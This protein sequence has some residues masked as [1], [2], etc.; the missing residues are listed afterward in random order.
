MSTKDK[1]HVQEGDIKTG[2]WY[3]DGCEM[4]R[5]DP[6]KT[7]TSKIKIN[8]KNQ[9]TSIELFSTDDKRT[10]SG[11]GAAGLVGLAVAG[12][13]GAVAGMLYGGKKKNETIVMCNLGNNKM[14]LAVMDISV[15]AKLKMCVAKNSA[16]PEEQKG[17]VSKIKVAKKSPAKKKTINS[18]K[19]AVAIDNNVET[20]ECPMCA[21]VVKSRAKICRFCRYVFDNTNISK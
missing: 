9:F 18:E 7:D 2:Y 14:F 12:P 8:I 21:E 1:I 5:Y 16:S 19:E 6:G 11:T 13:L 17:S 20:K 4:W 10:A 15:Y 3:L